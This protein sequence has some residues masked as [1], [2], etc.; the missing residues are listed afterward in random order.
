M[1]SLLH[2]TVMFDAAVNVMHWLYHS[3]RSRPQGD[4][5]SELPDLERGA[6]PGGEPVSST[7]CREIDL[8][9]ELCV[10]AAVA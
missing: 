10:V 4:P 9:E 1:F 2:A 6:G 7:A 5:P 3:L 8:K